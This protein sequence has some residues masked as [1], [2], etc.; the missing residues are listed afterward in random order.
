MPNSMLL[1]PIRFAATSYI[2]RVTADVAGSPTFADLT[3]PASGSLT[4]GRNY[5]LSGDGQADA[6]G[7]VGGVGDLLTLLDAC[8]ELHPTIQTFTV[9]L[10][11]TFL[12]RVTVS[13]A[14]L[15]ILHWAN[16]ATTLDESIFGFTNTDTASLGAHNATLLPQGIWRPKRATAIDTRDRQPVVGGIAHA[17]SGLQRTSRLALP[18]KERD[19]NWKFVNQAQILQEYE[20]AAEP[21]GSFEEAW[22]NSISFGRPFRYYN[23]E[24]SRTSTSYQ[25][26]VPRMLEDPMTRNEQF[27]IFWDIAIKA[28]AVS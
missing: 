12:V 26:Y 25:L 28:R 22:V 17:I 1:Y 15:C 9:T 23:D 10:E 5:W 4:I 14:T 19:L 2:F 18:R 20:L 27:K 13:G 3:F 16:A 7:G 8:L 6:D 21:F 11:S 24:T